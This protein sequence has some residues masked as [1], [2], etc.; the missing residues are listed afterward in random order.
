MKKTLLLMFI[1]LP[2]LLS[3][4]TWLKKKGFGGKKAMK[5]QIQQLESKIKADSIQFA[6]ELERMKQ[7]S[8]EKIDSAAKACGGSSDGKYYV[9]TGSFRNPNY[10]DEFSKKMKSMGYSSQ[11]VVAPNGFNLVSA[12]SGNSMPEVINALRNMQSTVDS[13][14]WI[15]TK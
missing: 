2:L 10:A 11:I 9:I 1:V 12:F 14:S 7:E 5:E 3:S 4:C 8:Q 15:Y 6:E 13:E